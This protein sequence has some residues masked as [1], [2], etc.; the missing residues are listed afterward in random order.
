M[1]QPAFRELTT[2]ARLCPMCRRITTH[3][4][5]DRYTRPAWKLGERR[6]Y[7]A[8]VCES[9]GREVVVTGGWR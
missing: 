1:T 9:C 6:K 2:S 8:W 7:T 5:K 4:L 3:H